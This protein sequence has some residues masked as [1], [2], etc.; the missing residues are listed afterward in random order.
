[1]DAAGVAPALPDRERAEY[2]RVRLRGLLSKG[3]VEAS[4]IG[5]FVGWRITRLGRAEVA[6]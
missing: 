4:G 2:V 3:L 6:P 1:M 5:Q